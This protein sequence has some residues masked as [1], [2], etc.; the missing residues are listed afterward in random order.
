MRKRLRKIAEVHKAGVPRKKGSQAESP[1]TKAF[2]SSRSA[3]C[4]A[5]FQSF[6]LTAAQPPA[7]GPPCARADHRHADES[8]NAPRRVL[9]ERQPAECGNW[10]LRPSAYWRPSSACHSPHPR[11]W[12]VYRSGSPPNRCVLRASFIGRAQPRHRGGLGGLGSDLSAHWS[13]M[14]RYSLAPRKRGR[15]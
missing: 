8:L 6:C 5:P 12:K 3:N 11:Q 15:R 7:H 10:T 14:T 9:A 1:A 2:A 13:Y 4:G